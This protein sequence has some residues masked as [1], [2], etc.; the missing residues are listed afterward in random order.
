MKRSIGVHYATDSII[1]SVDLRGYKWQ[2]LQY[3]KMDVP[4]GMMK[5][6]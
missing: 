6:R 1:E 2:T 3:E 4:A 5:I